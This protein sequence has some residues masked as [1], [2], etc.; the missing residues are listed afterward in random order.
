M[1]AAKM[2]KP[3]KVKPYST[4]PAGGFTPTL[5]WFPDV[6]TTHPGQRFVSATSY[7]IKDELAAMQVPEIGEGKSS[8]RLKLDLIVLNLHKSI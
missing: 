7:D 2:V 5:P 6:L 8:Q 3:N 1:I 4:L